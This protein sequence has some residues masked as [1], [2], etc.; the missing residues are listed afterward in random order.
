ME[1]GSKLKNARN[2]SGL[3]QEQAAEAIGVSR[4]TIS[5]WENNKSYPD[6]ISVIKMSDIYSV[7]L[8]HLLKEEKSMN[9]TYQEFLEESTNT[10]NAKQR[11]E[12]IILFSTYF[13]VWTIA[14]VIFWQVKG[15]VTFEC[16]VV[17]RWI[18]LPSVLLVMTIFIA[19]NNYWGK[20]N[21]FSVPV[22][23]IT[24]LTVPY[25]RF[26]EESGNATYTFRFPNFGYMLIGIIVAVCGICIGSLIRSRGNAFPGGGKK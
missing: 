4:Q 5:N 21:W 1:I 19:K 10:V 15:P 22:A 3:T 16:D 23:A 2:D 20:G 26:M 6:I 17:F 25:T 12:K 8:D 9:Q 11:L 18:L 13:L 14:M 24:Y 7:S